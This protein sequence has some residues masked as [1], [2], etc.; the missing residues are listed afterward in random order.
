MTDKLKKLCS[1]FLKMLTEEGC[2]KIKINYWSGFEGQIEKMGLDKATTTKTIIDEILKAK[3]EIL[4]NKNLL[5]CIVNFLRQK[6][7]ESIFIESI[8]DLFYSLLHDYDKWTFVFQE[9][10][11]ELTF[12]LFKDCLGKDLNQ[13]IEENLIKFFDLFIEVDFKLLTLIVRNKLEFDD[14]GIEILEK[15]I[16]EKSLNKILINFFKK[17]K[18]DDFFSYLLEKFEQTDLD[19]NLSSVSD[20]LISFIFILGQDLV[21]KHF[22]G[23]FI[24]T[25]TFL[26]ITLKVLKFLL[27]NLKKNRTNFE[28]I[29]A[30][31][32]FLLSLLDSIIRSAKFYFNY[33]NVLRMFYDLKLL[34]NFNRIFE[35]FLWYINEDLS[36][37]SNAEAILNILKQSPSSETNE[38][39]SIIKILILKNFESTKKLKY[40]NEDSFNLSNDLK[41]IKI[42]LSSSEILDKVPL[43]DYIL[44]PNFNISNL[45]SLLYT[46]ENSFEKAENNYFV[47][48]ENFIIKLLK[49]LNQLPIETIDIHYQNIIIKLIFQSLLII[50]E[51]N[52]ENINLKVFA[53]L[54]SFANKNSDKT[55]TRFE[56]YPLL[57]NFM[58]CLFSK[59]DLLS[60]NGKLEIFDILFEFI[61]QFIRQDSVANVALKL[62]VSLHNIKF[63]DFIENK[64]FAYKKCTE[65]IVLA[66]SGKLFTQYFSFI[67]ESLKSDNQN[68]Q[69][70]I[71]A[72]LNSYAKNY[73]GSLPSAFSD[74]LFTKFEKTID[75]VSETYSI[76]HIFAINSIYHILQKD[77][78]DSIINKI[79]ECFYSKKFLRIFEKLKDLI[80]DHTL[81]GLNNTET[82]FSFEHIIN[83]LKINQLEI[84]CTLLCSLAKLYS[85]FLSNIITNN[86]EHFDV[87][88]L[89]DKDNKI[90]QNLIK[91]FDYINDN[92]LFAKDQKSSFADV[93]FLN[94]FFSNGENLNFFYNTHTYLSA[95]NNLEKDELDYSH[96]N[97]EN[98][99]INSMKNE[100]MLNLIKTHDINL[101][102][103]IFINI[104]TYERLVIDLL[105]KKDTNLNNKN[106]LV[107]DSIYNTNYKQTTNNNDINL[108]PL[109]GLF[110]KYLIEQLQSLDTNNETKNLYEFILK[111]DI[112]NKYFKI[113]KDYLDC[114][115]LNVNLYS[116]YRANSEV[117]GLNFINYLINFSKFNKQTLIFSIRLLMNSNIFNRLMGREGKYLKEISE[118]INNVFYQITSFNSF[119]LEGCKYVIAIL[120][121]YLKYLNEVETSKLNF[122]LKYYG[123]VLFNLLNV[124]NNNQNEINKKY[125]EVITSKMNDQLIERFV[126]KIILS[127]EAQ[128]ND[129]SSLIE[130]ADLLSSLKKIPL[131]YCFNKNESL[132]S[133][134]NNPFFSILSLL[135]DIAN[136]SANLMK[137]LNL[138]LLNSESK[139]LNEIN[140][141]N[142]KLLQMFLL[143]Q[144]NV[145]SNK[146]LAI[147]IIKNLLYNKDLNF[148]FRNIFA[149]VSEIL[150]LF[151]KSQTLLSNVEKDLELISIF[152]NLGVILNVNVIK[153]IEIGNSIFKD[154]PVVRL[155]DRNIKEYRNAIYNIF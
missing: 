13:K 12:D 109:D 115:I 47:F 151:L 127:A 135:S 9:F 25:H 145:K 82:N 124:I 24:Y 95:I 11:G 8:F 128:S 34:T 19:L 89:S 64:K 100:R 45:V 20:F 125:K 43:F 99:K 91:S 102:K 79:Y 93:I 119:S 44:T 108:K 105:D 110:I 21:T 69:Q 112:V 54:F 118:L 67:Q 46:L 75:N 77:Q 23:D 113:V 106:S 146:K 139:S 147:D 4:T 48:N 38:T 28:Y 81:K 26:N 33:L 42:T 61:F 53:L 83:N 16:S 63:E 114:N 52:V 66:N 122:T 72:S 2:E 22:Q 134:L 40:L 51:L 74:F 140:K 39:N 29:Q 3:P 137:Y 104:L 132:N 37:K 32:K 10:L 71:Y 70:Y 152:K 123:Q 73:N 143:Y 97:S 62:L 55:L 116:V 1:S 7:D 85:L 107:I 50:Y 86:K 84:V 94:S 56:I 129:L 27:T 18:N 14:K 98:L 150:I 17:T 103:E 6:L 68:I 154:M 96:L 87:K 142:L 149:L 88:N 101:S 35:I 144:I 130:I 58:S 57:V 76:E 5:F 138:Y 65:L 155:N 49:A 31:E 153:R 60:K 136:D 121:N 148:E 80:S 15:L 36:N 59:F 92:I 111:H 117:F 78:P 90:I 131:L 41:D 126:D 120:D 133:K 141:Y 30:V